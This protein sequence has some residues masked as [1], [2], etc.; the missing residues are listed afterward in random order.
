MRFL[1]LAAVGVSALL[2]L[3]AA[4]D[5]SSLPSCAVTCAINAIGATGCATTDAKCICTA[6]SFLSGVQTCISTACNATDQAATLAFAQQFCGSAG[7]TITLPTAAA[8]SPAAGPTFTSSAAPASVPAATTSGYAPASYSAPPPAASYT[9]AAAALKQQWA[10]VAGL[11]GLG[12]AAM[13]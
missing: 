2:Q 11:I 12:V 1:T 4:Q 8:S 3:A 13:L 7:V 6:T 9:G 10:G 5:L